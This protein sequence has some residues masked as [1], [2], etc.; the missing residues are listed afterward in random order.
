M[1]WPTRTC[2]AFVTEVSKRKLY[3]V[4]TAWFCPKHGRPEYVEYIED[5]RP[6]R[7]RDWPPVWDCY[8]GT[9]IHPTSCTDLDSVLYASWQAQAPRAERK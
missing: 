9:Y 5:K 8:R 6:A 1:R 3:R 2:I 4:R 7:D